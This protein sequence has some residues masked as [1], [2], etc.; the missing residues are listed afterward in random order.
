M[1]GS[2]H[3][4]HQGK[5][6]SKVVFLR[7]SHG[8][9]QTGFPTVDVRLEDG[10]SLIA[11]KSGW[12]PDNRDLA[13][14]LMEW[15]FLYAAFYDQQRYRLRGEVV[16]EIA[17][18]PVVEDFDDIEFE[19]T[20]I[21]SYSE[22]AFREIGKAVG[23]RMQT[24]LSSAGMVEINNLL[25]TRLQADEDIQ[26][27]IEVRDRRL[28]QLPWHCWQFFEDYRHA[29]PSFSAP[30]FEQRSQRSPRRK[31]RILIVLGNREGIDSTQEEAVLRQLQAETT[32]LA[33]PSLKDLTEALRHPKGWDTFFFTGHSSS[34]TEGQ[35]FLNATDT[36]T[37]DDLR[38]A[39]ITAIAHG[40][41]L[42]IFNSCDG[43]KLAQDLQALNIPTAIV[44]KEPVPNQVAQD[45]V[46]SF[47]QAFATGA[48][49]HSAVRLAR[50]SLQGSEREFP[51]ASWLPGIWQNP[52][53]T[54]F[55]WK[56]KE[57][58]SLPIRK[59]SW[60]TVL[61]TSLMVA[62]LVIGARSLGWLN[63]PEL[64]AYDHLMQWQRPLPLDPRILLI[65]VTDDDIKTF[66]KPLKDETIH[67]LLQY[68]GQFFE[69]KIR[70]LD[71][72]YLCL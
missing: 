43:S 19:E 65:T 22:Q 69:S 6:V 5:T 34:Q 59:I 10:S 48:S 72:S 45:F 32:F 68:F 15:Q 16:E 20:G 14:F 51:C 17:P 9:L 52:A 50:E 18:L 33:E 49:L 11:Q 47:L 58:V 7:L 4:M 71:K 21:T 70:Y 28:Q 25:R 57:V 1:A 64:W 46:R 26:V 31:P 62:G 41:K 30:N 12:L 44:M 63:S 36:V 3:P 23:F 13:R 8:D 67:R 61:I 40:L 66:D 37:V 24:W 27:L 56:D 54:P 29:E 60:Q 55:R 53:V 39:L 2:F 35:F 38:Y 42:A